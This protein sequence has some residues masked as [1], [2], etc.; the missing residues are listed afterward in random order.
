MPVGE[1][2]LSMETAISKVQKYTVL[3]LAA[4][5]IVGMILSTVHLGTLIGEEIL[6]PPGGS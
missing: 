3:A 6:K 2:T 1:R 5:L 4:M